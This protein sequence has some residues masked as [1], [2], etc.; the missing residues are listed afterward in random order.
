MPETVRFLSPTD[1]HDIVRGMAVVA[2]LY[3]R[4]PDVRFRLDK[5]SGQGLGAWKDFDGNE[6]HFLFTPDGSLILGFDHASPMSP[7]ATAA[8]TGDFNTWPGLYDHLPDKLKARLEADPGFDDAFDYREVTFALWTTGQT[9][10]W[11]KGDVK[12]PPRDNGD[13]DGQ[14]YVLG[15]IKAFYDDFCAEFEEKYN[16]DL[17][18]DAVADLLSG[19]RVSLT[20]IRGL[21]ADANLAEA[22]KWLPEMG[23]VVDAPSRPG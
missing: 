6:C 21:K 12:Y 16:W 7:H 5:E 10:D 11:Q 15:R 17:D 18:P 19:D 23:F 22:R 2:K 13:P 8:E 14:K 9:R 4:D 3:D 20:C 1:L